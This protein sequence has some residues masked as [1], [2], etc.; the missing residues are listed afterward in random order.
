VSPH[1]PEAGVGAS[2]R[3][4]RNGQEKNGDREE[5]QRETDRDPQ[6]SEI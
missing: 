1:Q 6:Q 4:G 3:L 5:D 2:E